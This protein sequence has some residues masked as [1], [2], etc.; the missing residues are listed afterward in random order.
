MT[1]KQAEIEQIVLTRLMRLNATVY[2]IVA[3]VMAGLGLF[4][5]TNWLI[6]KG[7]PMGP[8]GE[9]IIGPN[10]HLLSQFFIG[11][12]ISF[13]GSLIGFVYAFITGFIIAYIFA[14]IYN[15]IAGL[16]DKSR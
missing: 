14:W 2:G 10:L 11:Y 13:V 8:E 1:E 4:V 5:V 16:R 15:M 7:G 6:L 9:P 12:Q 3:G